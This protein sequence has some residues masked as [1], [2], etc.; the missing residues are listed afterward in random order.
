MSHGDFGHGDFGHGDFG[1]SAEYGHDRN[2]MGDN[3]TARVRWDRRPRACVDNQEKSVAVHVESHGALDVKRLFISLA[4][5]G[6]LVPIDKYRPN[7]LAEDKVKQ[8]LLDADA[9]N[10]PDNEKVMPCGYYPGATGWTRL[11]REFW[12]IG[13]RHT[14]W[15][16]WEPLVPDFSQKTWI[17]VSCVTWCY[18]EAGDLQTDLMFEVKVLPVWDPKQGIWMFDGEPFDR[19]KAAAEKLARKMC[20]VITGTAP[21]PH[22]KR[23]RESARAAA[24]I[25]TQ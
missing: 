11:W 4:S 7:L 25:R 10:P 23:V 1:H 2:G 12:Q 22:A 16:F 20:D 24:G 3:D 17:E 6:G 13:A 21:F 5:E 9:W 14:W 18:T 8:Q 15:K 19:H